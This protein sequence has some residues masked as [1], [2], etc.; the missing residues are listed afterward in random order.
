MT[1][2]LGRNPD[3]L[4]RWYEILIVIGEKTRKE[5]DSKGLKEQ[6]SRFEKILWLE[7][8]WLLRGKLIFIELKLKTQDF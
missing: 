8:K 7:E 4:C 1:T 2:K 5:E 6:K 3:W